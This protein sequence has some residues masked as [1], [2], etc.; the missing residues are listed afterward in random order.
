MASG[1][2]IRPLGIRDK[3]GGRSAYACT[4]D[5]AMRLELSSQLAPSH[6][7]HDDQ[8]TLSSSSLAMP[9]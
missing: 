1:V 9:G 4:L 8:Q 2:T 7:A 3:L 5:G 6:E